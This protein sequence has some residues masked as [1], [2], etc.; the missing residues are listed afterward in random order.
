M[1]STHARILVADDSLEMART[2]ADGL[3]DRG[4]DTIA[5]PGG[6][7]AVA[8]L[9]T[10]SIDAVVTDVQMSGVD[11]LEVLAASRR[12]D[13]HRPVIVMTAYSALDGAIESIRRGA[14]YY[15]TKPFQ[16]EE[17]AIFLERALDEQRVRRE[18]STLRRLLAD[19]AVR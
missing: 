9:A 5:V 14:A 16:L 13:P 1:N 6:G 10:E 11:G 12:S 17:L 4:Y 2:I 8:R 7:E 3:A 15:L 19:R 18:V